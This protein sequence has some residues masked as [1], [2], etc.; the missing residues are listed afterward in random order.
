MT[1][2][3]D[4]VAQPP[5]QGQEQPDDEKDDANDHAEMGIGKGG[6]QSGQEEPKDYEDDPKGN[7]GVS[8]VSG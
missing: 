8:P 7:H 2:T 4:S 3:A 5:H 6:D 1:A